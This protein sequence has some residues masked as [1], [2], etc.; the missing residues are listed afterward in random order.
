MCKITKAAVTAE[1]S[2]ALARI[3]AL[4]K[5]M[6]PVLAIT[7]P[8]AAVYVPAAFAVEGAADEVLASIEGADT[9]A[10]AIATF[11]AKVSPVK[12]APA[13]EAP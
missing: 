1:L 3:E 10:D 9:H 7:F 12:E 5:A 8:Q 2:A 11:A 6:L 13:N 4:E